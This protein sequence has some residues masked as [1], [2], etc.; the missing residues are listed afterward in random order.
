MT[1]LSETANRWQP[2][3]RFRSCQSGS[4]AVEFI[5]AFPA[6]VL[7]VFGIIEVAMVMFVLVLAEGGLREA[8]RYG[9]TGQVP[10]TMTREEMIVQMIEDHTHGLIDL[11]SADLSHLVYPSFDDIGKPEPFSDDN[12][13]GS[14]DPGESFTD[15]N[16]NATWDPDMGAAGLG[17]PGDVVLYKIEFQWD[18]LLG[19]FRVFGGPDGGLDLS[20]SVAVQNEPFNPLAP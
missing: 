4:A 20:A 12:G 15:I 6:L 16:G 9:I 17:G 5:F 10:G 18:F 14:W 11:E 13:N 8:S 2:A 3:R 19:V 1:S 7:L